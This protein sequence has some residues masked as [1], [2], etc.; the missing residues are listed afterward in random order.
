MSEQHPH[1]TNRPVL[2]LIGLTLLIVL[3]AWWMID[4]DEPA[5]PDASETAASARAGQ[6][7]GSVDAGTE[8]TMGQQDERGT[9]S[10]RQVAQGVQAAQA[11]GTQGT[12]TPEKAISPNVARSLTRVIELLNA[13]KFD[14]ALAV[15]EPL[16]SAEAMAR[17]S[18][19]E[20]SRLYQISFNLN[21]QAENFEAA[22]ADLEAALESG[23][24][25][26]R[27]ATQMQYMR[28]QLF[29]Q[30]EDYGKAADSLE[31]WIAEP[32]STPNK[33]AYYLLAASYY[34]QERYDDARDHMET[35][36]TMPGE[37]QEG[38]Y[39]MMAS[40]Y[41]QNEDYAKA[42]PVVEKMVELYDDPTYREQLDGVNKELAR[43]Q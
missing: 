2:I 12:E 29:V 31:Q 32:E 43:T 17:M 21:M 36:F 13:G 1:N 30:M 10:A 19:F 11:A 5:N 34:Y 37:N 8:G 39:S 42:K 15:L 35:L 38:W 40:L 23:G 16:L 41:I 14:E 24:L 25:D 27:E 22:R 6:T 20:Q 28:A 18:P 33:A 4:F 3:E 26:Q 7:A 9:Q